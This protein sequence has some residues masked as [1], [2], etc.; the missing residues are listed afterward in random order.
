MTEQKFKPPIYDAAKVRKNYLVWFDFLMNILISLPSFKNM[1]GNLPGREIM[2]RLIYNGHATIY[3]API[4]GLVTPMN[5]S[6]YG[7]GLYGYPTTV[8]TSD[9]FLGTTNLKIGIDCIVIYS[10]SQAMINNR[11]STALLT[12][13]KYARLLAEITS[14]IAISCRNTRNPVWAVAQDEKTKRA[15]EQYFKDNAEGNSAIISTDDKIFDTFKG[16]NALTP[17]ASSISDLYDAIEDT[18]RCFYREIGIR[19]VEQ[20]QERMI[21]PEMGAMDEVLF[22]NIKDMQMCIDEGI[23]KMN[24][25]FGTKSYVEW[26]VCKRREYD[27]QRIFGER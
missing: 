27:N 11:F 20:K 26:D 15:V 25:M 5:S 19:Y 10:D 13:Q 21:V 14:S 8:T 3:K 7:V 18:M 4:A 12:I 6:L 17:S 1:P 24:S 16:I 2:R 9:T 23:E 22:S